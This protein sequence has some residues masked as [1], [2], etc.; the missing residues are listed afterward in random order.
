MTRMLALALALA[1][2]T[3]AASAQSTEP[4]SSAE[5][6]TTAAAAPSAHVLLLPSSGPS[7]ED[8]PQPHGDAPTGERI[9]R[10]PN[11]QLV[12]AG[13]GTFVGTYLV[14]LVS[15]LTVE[16]DS[17]PLCNPPAMAPPAINGGSTPRPEC[18]HDFQL[19]AIPIVGPFLVYPMR[20]PAGAMA[21]SYGD[22]EAGWA[23]G[24]ALDAIGQI[25][26]LT[27]M[28][29]GFIDEQRHSVR[30]SHA[31]TRLRIGGGLGSLSATLT[32]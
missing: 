8:V 29:I 32:F 13:L 2:A 5:A 15:A 6:S 20:L 7:P 1:L 11:W 17:S 3:S 22:L 26:G 9:E 25:A 30:D 27:M 21:P 19:A 16:S 28:I 24:L 14:A 31:S 18:F 10:H 4:V 23:V 12:I